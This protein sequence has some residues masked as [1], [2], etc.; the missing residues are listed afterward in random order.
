VRDLVINTKGLAAEGLYVNGFTWSPTYLVAAKTAILF[1]AGFSC[2]GQL[3][4]KD[5]KKALA[6]QT[7]EFLFLTHVHYDHC[8]S[9]SYLKKIFPNLKICASQ[10]S[11]EIIQRENAVSLMSSL[12]QYVIPLIAQL[13]DIREEELL[14]GPFQPFGIDIIFNREEQV[15]NIDDELSVRIF[16]TPGHTRDMLSYYIPERK[17][18][19]AT[20][21][22]GCLGRDGHIVSEFLVDYDA[23]INTLK[24]FS[25]LDVETFC[26]GHHF[27]FTGEDVQEFFASSLQAAESFKKHVDELLYREKGSIDRVV[28]VIKTEEY[29]MN[30]EI[31]QPERAYLLN[32]KTQ[33]THL[34]AKLYEE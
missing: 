7:P 25:A 12:S 29:D 4:E 27:V 2:M 3:Y 21:S 18:L 10:R 30:P 19:I 13:P 14:M 16:A 23:Y 26:Q 9:A 20:E 15:I 17:I 11:Y 32:L 33:V 6:N 28:D 1:E 8:G 5:I 34:A 24:R 31:K 22:A